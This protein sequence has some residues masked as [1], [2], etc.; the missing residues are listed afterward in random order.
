MVGDRNPAVD[1]PPSSRIP[2]GVLDSSK[3]LGLTQI[4]RSGAIGSQ[5]VN[6]WQ[7]TGHNR[8]LSNERPPLLRYALV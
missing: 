7:C 3:Q 6:L 2:K 1:V 5:P 4:D 8:F